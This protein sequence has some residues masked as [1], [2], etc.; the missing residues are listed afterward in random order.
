MC[1]PERRAQRG[2]SIVELMVGIVV[3]LL[4]GLAATTSAVM[5]NASQRQGIAS[6]GVTVNATTALA[7][8]KN[9]ATSAG[10]GFLGDGRPLCQRLNLSVGA[11]MMSD[12][13]TFSPVRIT[14]EAQGDRID[15]FYGTNV[16]AGANV[17]LGTSS[18]G[19]AAELQSRLPVAVGEAVLLAPEALGDPCVVRSVT[20][21]APATE[22][23]AQ[24]LDFGSGGAH[25]AKAFTT[26][27]DFP[28]RARVTLLGELRWNRYR[29]EDGNLIQGGVE[30]T[31]RGYRTFTKCLAC[32]NTARE[33]DALK[34]A[35]WCPVD[36]AKRAAKEW[37]HD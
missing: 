16:Q 26:A 5:F 36:A 34:H 9:D 21:A 23:T 1:A 12:G 14:A 33:G 13:E 31:P 30:L 17:L 8:L 28:E 11:V 7:A 25:N 3:A 32:E 15:V 4:V 2:L 6:G 18:D 19:S 37:G 10:L 22:T 20:A 35:H 24:Q 27:P 29:L